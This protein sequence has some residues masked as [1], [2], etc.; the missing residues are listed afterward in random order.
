MN[1]DYI[2]LGLI[3]VPVIFA[4][5]RNNISLGRVIAKS[6]KDGMV[7]TSGK[8]DRMLDAQDKSFN[9][10]KDQHREVKIDHKELKSEMHGNKDQLKDQ[11]TKFHY[12]MTRGY[13]DLKHRIDKSKDK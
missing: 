13:D 4:M 7:E 8:A 6:V 10:M 9:I 5:W 12:E 2:K 11:I 3:I 1:E